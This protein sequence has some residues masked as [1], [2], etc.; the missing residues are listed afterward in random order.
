MVGQVSAPP[1]RVE[2]LAYIVDRIARSS[3]CPSYGEIGLAM[4]PPVHSSRAA[5]F[6]NQLVRE[7]FI[8]RPPASRRGIVIRDLARCRLA[9]ELAL[10]E[11]GYA[12]AQPLGILEQPPSTFGELPRIPPFEH[13]PDVD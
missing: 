10:G 9:I 3:T 8:E 5:Q 2:A 12:H 13:I 11:L 4:R 6:V 1:R 7:G